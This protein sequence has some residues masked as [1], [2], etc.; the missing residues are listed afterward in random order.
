MSVPAP[1]AKKEFIYPLDRVPELRRTGWNM[2]ELVREVRAAG[3]IITKR[4]VKGWVK[5]GLLPPP[6][7]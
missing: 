4:I 6:R 7:T 3:Y 2:N 5:N 1:D